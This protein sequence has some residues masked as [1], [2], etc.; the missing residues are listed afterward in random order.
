MCPFVRNRVPLSCAPCRHKKLKCS[1]SIPCENCIR[2]GDAAGCAYA[3]PGPRRKAAPPG[4]SPDDMQNRIDRLEGLVLSLMT[5]GSTARTD[6]SGG[7]GGERRSGSTSTSTADDDGEMEKIKEEEEYG[8]GEEGGESDVDA[9]ANSFGVLKVDAETE[10]TMYIGDSHWH[11]VLSDI[12]EVRNY[13]TNHKREL[14]NQYKK[15]NET[16]AASQMPD[17]LFQGLAPTTEIELRAGL[18]P[19]AKV[20]SLRASSTRSIRSCKCCTTRRS[21]SGSR[22]FS[23]TRRAR[24]WRGWVCSTRR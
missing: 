2:R 17:F 8:E 11:L 9:V 16:S 21:M 13:F 5:N 1:R 20:E 15:V 23:R 12:A 7:G 19:R 14:D 10:K 4:S 6:S 18:P 22:R 3:A 24:V